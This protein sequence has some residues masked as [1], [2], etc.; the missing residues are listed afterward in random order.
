MDSGPVSRINS[1]K[2]LN[3]GVVILYTTV[4]VCSCHR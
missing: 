4:K 3:A 1:L 2:K